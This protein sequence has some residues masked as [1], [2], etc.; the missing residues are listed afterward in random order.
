MKRSYIFCSICIIFLSTSCALEKGNQ[1][2][3][4][5]F[6]KTLG[7][8]SSIKCTDLNDDGILDIVLGAGVNELV[9]SDSCVVALNGKNGKVLWA[10]AGVDQMVGTAV[11]M[12]INQDQTDDVV[13]G[14]RSAQ[15]KA[16]NGKNGKTL[17][18][19]KVTNHNRD[20]KGF[21]RFNF[22][23]PQIIPDQNQDGIQELLVSNGGNLLAMQPDGSDRFPGVLAIIDGSNGEILAAD[24]MPDKKESYMSPLIWNFDNEGDADIL[25]GSGGELV[26][27]HLYKTR[28]KDLLN[29]DISKALVLLEEQGHGFIAPPTLADVNEDGK[30]DFIVNWHGGACFAIDGNSHEILWTVKIPDSELNCSPTPGDVNH[31]GIPDFFSQFSKGVWP[32]NTASVQ[33]LIDGKTGSIL[34]QE[35][36]GCAG[37][38]TALSYDLNN[39]GASEFIYSVND[40]NCTGIHLANIKHRL[41]VFDFANQSKKI[42][43]PEIKAK[44]VSSTPWIGDLDG[45]KELELIYCIQANFSQIYSYFGIQI[46]RMQLDT[47]LNDHA[48]WTS[49]MGSESTGSF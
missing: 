21:M 32:K 31:D 28:L 25:F 4:S 7:T 15:L 5:N 18:N 27:G 8:S 19:F 2:K 46:S 6:L 1:V 3:W 35:S 38:A 9:A 47:K 20:A 14:G 48:S 24:V 30:K 42:L 43:A 33:V 10:N 11:F 36:D 23:N 34:H 49:Y 22:Y 40:F 12:D 39:D 45:D 26:G 29:N 44:N 41:M 37:F 17:W 16:I 13:I